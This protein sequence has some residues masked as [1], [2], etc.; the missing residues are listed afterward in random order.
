MNYQGQDGVSEQSKIEIDGMNREVRYSN[1][2]NNT[3]A[4]SMWPGFMHKSDWFEVQQ[5]NTVL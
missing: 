5:C 1:E 3:S 4:I 2:L